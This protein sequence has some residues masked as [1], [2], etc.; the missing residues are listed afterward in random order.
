MN[1]IFDFDGTLA[2]TLSITVEIINQFFA[3]RNIPPTSEEELRDKGGMKGLIKAHHIPKYLIPYLVVYG[4]YKL[5]KRIKDAKPFKGLPE[6]LEKLSQKHTLGIVTSNSKKNIQIF[7]KNNNL[8]K[9]FTFVS[10][11]G[12][13]FDKHLKIMKIISKYKLEHHNTIYI[14]DETRDV[15]AAKKSKLKSVAV[16]WGFESKESLEESDPEKII[17]SVSDLLKL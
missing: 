7:L 14:G 17:T 9:Y 2:D 3:K 12:G 4:R 8:E 13:L 11:K 15:E 5:S 10:S 16:A 1:L 6:V